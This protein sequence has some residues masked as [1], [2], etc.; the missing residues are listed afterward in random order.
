MK[1]S[2]SEGKLLWVTERESS[3]SQYT[4]LTKGNFEGKE[5]KN[6]AHASQ[7]Y[8]YPLQ[9]I[10]N[11][12]FLDSPRSFLFFLL[13]NQSFSHVSF[14]IF[15]AADQLALC[16]RNRQRSWQ[17]TVIPQNKYPTDAFF[18]FMTDKI[19][20]K[21]DAMRS[22]CHKCDKA[23]E[24]KRESVCSCFWGKK[25]VGNWSLCPSG[26]RGGGG[27]KEIKLKSPEI[28]WR[29][30]ADMAPRQIFMY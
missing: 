24:G 25:T 14:F 4:R 6:T 23:A 9:C 2:C 19:N 22:E 10:L 29:S 8:I 28:K 16:F 18:F 13:P 1:V 12:I 21:Q 15:Q 30:N 26:W 11:V 7:L 5:K 17:T 27:D 20:D 3:C